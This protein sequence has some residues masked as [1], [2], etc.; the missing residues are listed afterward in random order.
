MTASAMGQKLVLFIIAGAMVNDELELVY[1]A[2]Y[3]NTMINS[4]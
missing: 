2:K 1:V 3:I 4:V